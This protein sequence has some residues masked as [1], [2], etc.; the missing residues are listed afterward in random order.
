MTAN[1][2]ILHQYTK[3]YLVAEVKAI[4]FELGAKSQ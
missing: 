3:T 4:N 2:E 1:T